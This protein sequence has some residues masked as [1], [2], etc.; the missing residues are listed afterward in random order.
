[1]VRR[2]PLPGVF[3]PHSDSWLLAE[4]L[5][6]E[7]LGPRTAVLDLCTGSGLLA[8]VAAKL[9]VDEVTAVDVS[10]RAVVSARLGALLNGVRVRAVRGD[11]FSPLGARRF[12]V[13]VSNPPYLPGWAPGRGSSRAWEGGA[14]GRDFVDRICAEAPRHLTPGGVLLLV[15]SSV[16]GERETLE[17]LA[18]HGLSA[19][20]AARRRGPLGELLRA[21]AGWLRER[22]LL[23]DDGQ[24]D[25]IVFR[26]QRPGERPRKAA[27]SAGAN[28]AWRRRT[29]SWSGGACAS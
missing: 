2:L 19:G 5:G 25:V 15:H 4:C 18:A 29:R 1:V 7:R 3:Q 21:R 26:G 27:R 23:E 6:R 20:V 14:R 10:A 11:L 16:C 12:D 24:E 22:G 13:I 28:R 8:V 9:G 17:A